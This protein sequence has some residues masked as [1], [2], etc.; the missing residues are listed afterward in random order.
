M[1]KAPLK[2]VCPLVCSKEVCVTWLL[3][4]LVV[5][6]DC[7]TRSQEAVGSSKVVVMKWPGHSLFENILI[8]LKSLLF[9]SHGWANSWSHCSLLEF[10]WQHQGAINH[11]LLPDWGFPRGGTPGRWRVGLIASG[12]EDV[13]GSAMEQCCTSPAVLR[14]VTSGTA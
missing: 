13:W 9:S 5:C 1:R 11:S 8:F 2:E 14:A 7:D 12:T 4:L 6:S 10:S 3:R